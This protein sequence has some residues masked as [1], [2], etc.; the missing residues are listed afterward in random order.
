MK[1][2]LLKRLFRA[3]ASDDTTAID[4]LTYLV[5][6]EERKKGHTLLAEQLERIRKQRK[7]EE[8]SLEN[9]EKSALI[10]SDTFQALQELPTNK[11]LNLP[12]VTFITRE[13][14]RHHMILPEAI[15]KRFRRVER[16]YA[17]RD[18]LAHY[19]LRYRQKILLYGSPGCGKTLGAERL[20]WNTG[21]PLLKIRFDAMVS[22]FLGETA[23]NLRLVF[24]K[25]SEN[26]CLLFLDECDSIAKSREDIQEVGE[27]K[28]VVNTFLQILD[29]YESSSGLLVAA[30]NLDKSLDNALWRRFDD[31][32]EVPL[33][34]RD[35]L[36]LILKQNLST[37]EAGVI[38]W[39]KI[40]QKMAGFSAAQAVRV[41]QDAAKRA[42]LEREDLVIQ[43]HLEEAIREIQL[44]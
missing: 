4:K 17:A 37:I 12:L 26:P 25:A 40:I 44:S 19:G 1:A 28:R 24:D 6:E 38:N 3:I 35:E 2:E 10:A 14:L 30:T 18:R 34:G 16:E 11:R 8:P 42:I 33:P 29:D 21:L 9:P 31:V 43:E 36:E 20:A 22:S 41:A 7:T 39:E 27:M 23:S 13:K 15:E 5:I 32:I